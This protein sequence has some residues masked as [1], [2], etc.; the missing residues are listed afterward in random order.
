MKYRPLF[1]CLHGSHLYG[2]DTPESDKDYKGVFM[3]DTDELL[4]GTS[5]KQ[6]SHSTGSDHSKNSSEDTDTTWYSLPEF[7]KLASQGEIIAIDMLYADTHPE[8][9]IQWSP[10]WNTYPLCVVSSSPKT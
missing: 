5:P 4:L 2:L 1:K 8:C 6:I 9:I 10:E 3:P 7:I